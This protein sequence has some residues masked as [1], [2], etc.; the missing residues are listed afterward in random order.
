MKK[1]L[2]II[3]EK[4][5]FI[6]AMLCLL[7]LLLGA[8]C[9]GQAKSK[10]GKE[11]LASSWN[12]AGSA[13]APVEVKTW[14]K[15]EPG[16][17]YILD[18]LPGPHAYSGRIWLLDPQSEKVMGEIVSGSNPDFAL[19]P[20]GTRLFVASRA[21][22]GSS[23][24]A[25]ID[26][27]SGDVIQRA[28]FDFRVV[29]NGLPPFSTMAVSSDG[30]TV[31]IL[32]NSP[33]SPETDGFQ[34]VTFN[35]QTGAFLP[36]RVHLGNCGYGR[37][38]DNSAPDQFDFLCPTTNRIRRVHLDAQ[39]RELDNAFVV[40]PWVRRLGVAQA[41][42]APGAG[43]LTIV[44]GDG[45][46][47]Q[48]NA[49]AATFAP[50]S[51]RGDVQ[52]RIPPAVWPVSSDGSRL[53][54][55]YSRTPNPRFYLDY[56]RSAAQNPRTQTADEFRVLDTTTWRTIGHIKTTAPFWSAV[57]AN[58]GPLLYALA[59]YSHSVLVIDAA[60]MHQLRAIPVGGTPALALV[61]P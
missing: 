3:K 45:A 44:R 37:F 38:I 56:D 57:A 32:V 61:A 29:A 16:W 42:P 59:P 36:E 34:L 28:T 2:T 31:R 52:G 14:A 9:F 5:V 20:D 18:P 4:S 33:T 26:T 53:Y 43:D 11:P 15:P 41:F 10:A 39:S 1:I 25:V 23:N 8:S 22:G 47:F 50:T 54:L 19:S 51:M 12:T 21:K 27:A 7:P 13:T 24:L 35:I 48:M 46:V 55:G 30:L 58:E 6:P 17:L 49:D 60:N 40:L